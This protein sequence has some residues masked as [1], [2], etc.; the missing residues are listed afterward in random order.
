MVLAFSEIHPDYYQIPLADKEA[1]LA[2]Q[3]E[4][5]ANLGEK[6]LVRDKEEVQYQAIQALKAL[7]I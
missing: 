2:E 7:L 5:E 3:I 4:A 1:L 6:D